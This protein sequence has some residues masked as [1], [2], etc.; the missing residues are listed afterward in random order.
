MSFPPSP[1]CY[2]DHSANLWLYNLLK[3]SNKNAIE[4]FH[5]VWNIKNFSEQINIVLEKPKLSSL[6]LIICHRIKIEA[7]ILLLRKFEI[8]RRI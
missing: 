6:T 2:N 3:M 7:T 5:Y 4:A 1:L 8:F